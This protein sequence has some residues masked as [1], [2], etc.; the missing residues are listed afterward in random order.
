MKK[1]LLSP[2]VLILFGGV[3]AIGVHAQPTLKNAFK[4]DFLI[5]TALLESRLGGENSNEMALIKSQFNAISPQNALKWM[6]VHPVPGVYR[7]APADRFVEFGVENHMFIVGHTLVWHSQTPSW[8][9]QDDKGKPLDR[10]ALLARMREHIFTVVGRYEGKISGRDVVNEA[11]NEDGTLRQSQWQKIIGDDYIEKAFQYAHEAD[12]NAEL[13]Y[14]DFSLENSP[15]RK[16][17][18]ELI[19]KLKA[20][21]VPVTGIGFEGHYKM[22][23]PAPAQIEAAIDDFAKLGVKVAITELDVDMLPAATESQAAEVSMNFALR[24]EL[25]PYTNGLPDSVQQ[26]LAKR[27]ADLFTAFLKQRGAISRVTFWGVTDAD[28]WLNDWPVRGRT[29]YPLLFDRRGQ[30]KPAF[31]AVIKVARHP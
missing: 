15:K 12:P 11:L 27:Y 14:N 1:N 10:D 28:S 4:N 24:A 2:V 21:G 13:Y 29:S 26:A 8:V 16:G 9:F 6:F 22:G 23:W 31:E 20:E 19:K 17:A 30:P 3:F 5:G 18:V 7:F 25:N